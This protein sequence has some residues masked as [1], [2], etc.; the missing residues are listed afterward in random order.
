VPLAQ[1]HLDLMS[2]EAPFSSA[3]MLWRWNGAEKFVRLDPA[4]DANE[5]AWFAHLGSVG[6][7]EPGGLAGHL[8]CRS[9]NA[10]PMTL[11]GC[12]P[13]KSTVVVDAALLVAQSD[14]MATRGRMSNTIHCVLTDPARAQAISAD[15]A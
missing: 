4:S 6:C 12:D 5:G 13:F 7:T 9:P 2:A 1:N 14:L 15:A 11:M 8:R 3:R 10:P